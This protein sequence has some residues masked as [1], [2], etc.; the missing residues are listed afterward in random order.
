MALYDY[1]PKQQSP[2]DYTAFE[3]AF[4]AGDVIHV[5]GDP[6]PDGFFHG[7]VSNKE[8]FFYYLLQRLR[9]MATFYV[10]IEIDLRSLL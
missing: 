7:E 2:H 3:L 10:P 4:Q 1:N 5:Y 6:R 8:L 9:K